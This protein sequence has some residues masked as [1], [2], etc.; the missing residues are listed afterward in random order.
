M[1]KEVHQ[2]LSP[3][4]VRNEK[5]PGRYAD[6]N[7]LY[8]HVSDSGARW[9]LWRGTIRGHKDEKGHTIRYER[10]IGSA[11]TYSLAE[12]REIAREWRKLAR[13]GIDPGQ[14]RDKVLRE[15]LTFE[16]AARKVWKEQIE[17]HP[18]NE[19]HK[20]QWISTLATY[21]FPLIG[22]RPVHTITQSDILRILSPIWTE[23]AE[24]ARRV[25]QRLRTVLDWARTAGYCEGVSPVEGVEKGLPKQRHKTEHLAALPYDQ[26]PEV[27]KGLEQDER[28]GA[29]ALRFLILTAMRSG[30]VRGAAWS[31]IDFQSSTWIIPA[32]RMKM[33]REH[34]VP[35]SGEALAVLEKVKGLSDDLVF[36][37]V[38]PGRQLSAS[39]LFDV[40]EEVKPGFTV[41]GMRSTFRDWAEEC[42]AFPHEV[43]EAALAHQVRNSVE[44][45]YRRTDLFE[46]RR[47]LMAAWGRYCASATRKGDVVRLPA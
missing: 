3:A 39:Y 12:A 42:T 44:R 33:G 34:R 15:T 32:D 13:E 18:G 29:L 46:K 25:K 10:G 22:N 36:P 11:R 7:G 26:L 21:A 6:G 23:R 45:A 17:P 20:A 31:E 27:M 5:K 24:T 1:P 38:K 28:M 4:R 41:H 37:S 47:E 14:E 35:L 8:L 16:A 40:L 30:E 43:K 19:K 2:G 9:W